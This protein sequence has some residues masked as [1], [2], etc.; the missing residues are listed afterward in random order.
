LLV[1]LPIAWDWNNSQQAFCV[2]VYG[3]L[4][5]GTSFEIFKFEGTPVK[6]HSFSRGCFI[7]DPHPLRR[8]LP[9]GDFTLTE[10]TK[11][12]IRDL[13]LI[14]ETIFDV[15]LV[16]YVNSLNAFRNQSEDRCRTEGK[17]R[18]GLLQWQLWDQAIT[19]ARDALDKCREAE[20]DR[21]ADVIDRANVTVDE[22][23][24]ALEHRYDFFFSLC[25][26]FTSTDCVSVISVE[27]VPTVY[28][29]ELIMS[30]WVDIEVERM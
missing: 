21:R 19:S 29:T 9:I 20:V 14:C 23:F 25:G 17:P 27:L 6:P 2:P 15:M 4:C 3:I 16:S 10:N 13:R 18:N 30:G 7:G 28:K 12:F 8:G 26:E 11:P 1:F 22:A 5:G 24:K